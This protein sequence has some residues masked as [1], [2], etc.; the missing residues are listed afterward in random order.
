MTA[1]PEHPADGRVPAIPHTINA[2]G[3]ALTGEQRARFY[4]EVLAAEEDDVSGVMRRWWKVAML[5]RARGAETSRANAAG[6]R[7]VAVEDLLE[8]VERAA[9]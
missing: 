9:G 4:G 2:I 8:Q 1:Q 7:L 5:D 6:R 3:D